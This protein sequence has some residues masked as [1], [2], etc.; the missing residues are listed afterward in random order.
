MQIDLID[1]RHRPDG[2]YHWIGHYMDH[3]SKIHVLFPLM[4]KSAEEVAVNLEAKVFAYFGPPKIL[5]SDNGREFVN[6]IIHKLVQDWPGEITVVNGRA[7]HPQSQGLVERG[8][9]KVEEMLACRFKTSEEENNDT[10]WTMWLPQI[11]CK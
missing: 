6:T 8:N 9:A 5:Q 3:W 11:Q 7:R 2:A 1:M 10:S 4:R